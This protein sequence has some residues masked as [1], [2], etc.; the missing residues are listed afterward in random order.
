MRR[1]HR[2][3]AVQGVPWWQSDICIQRAAVRVADQKLPKASGRWFPILAAGLGHARSGA[4]PAEAP[5]GPEPLCFRRH[6]LASKDE[7]RVLCCLVEAAEVPAH[8]AKPP[9][10]GNLE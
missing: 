5:L 4:Q 3:G 9:Q 7:S 2:R 10:M 6:A 8:E 1:D